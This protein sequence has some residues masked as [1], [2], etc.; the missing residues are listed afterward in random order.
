[1]IRNDEFPHSCP[2]LGN[3]P[4]QSLLTNWQGLARRARFTFAAHRRQ[5]DPLSKGTQQHRDLSPLLVAFR[6]TH[7]QVAFDADLKHRLPPPLHKR[8]RTFTSWIGD[9]RSTLAAPTSQSYD[10]QSGCSMIHKRGQTR[11]STRT[12][13]RQDGAAIHPI[14]AEDPCRKLVNLFLLRYYTHKKVY[15]FLQFAR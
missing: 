4:D 8:N 13:C 7:R 2:S 3:D 9:V 14:L 15:F 1:M 6:K 11:N 5:L 10:D 12:S